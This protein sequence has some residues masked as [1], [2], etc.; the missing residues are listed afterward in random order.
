MG[1]EV[2]DRLVMMTAHTAK[3]LEF[4]AVFLTGMEHGLFPHFNA[5]EEIGGVEEERRGGVFRYCYSLVG[6]ADA[7]GDLGWLRVHSFELCEFFWLYGG[8]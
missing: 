2:D 5:L 3:G 7:Q 1:T 8:L 4:D 6:A